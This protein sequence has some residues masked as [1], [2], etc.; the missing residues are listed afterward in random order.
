MSGLSSGDPVGAF[1]SNTTAAVTYV[2]EMQSAD[3]HYSLIAVETDFGQTRTFLGVRAMSI[4]EAFTYT[5]TNFSTAN[6][7]SN[8]IIGP[9]L[10]AQG[11]AFA[12]GGRVEVIAKTSVAYNRIERNQGGIASIEDEA[13]FLGEFGLEYILQPSSCLE[14]S[15]G[16]SALGII[17]IGHAAYPNEQDVIYHMLSIGA[18]LRR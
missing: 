7:T 2:T 8:R 9:Q 18:T 5:S 14:L 1:D 15:F 17:N 4:D 12:P 13:T 11:W 16:Y 10:G 3:A 6:T